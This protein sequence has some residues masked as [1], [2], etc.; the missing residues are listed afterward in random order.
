METDVIPASHLYC[1][2]Y[3]CARFHLVSKSAQ[4][5]K[6]FLAK[7]RDYKVDLGELEPFRNYKG[8]SIIFPKISMQLKF[9][10]K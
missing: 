2:Y 1:D 6:K 10:E 4:F 8:F 3:Q 9:C 7:P 5:T